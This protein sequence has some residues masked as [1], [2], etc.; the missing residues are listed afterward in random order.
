M[1]RLKDPSVAGN[2]PVEDIR[3]RVLVIGGGA[4]AGKTTAA[5]DVAARYG[6]SVSEGLGTGLVCRALHAE[7]TS[8]SSLTRLCGDGDVRAVVPR[9]L[10]WTPPTASGSP[11]SIEALD[12]RRRVWNRGRLPW[13]K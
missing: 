5:R 8:W 3:W 1:G 2:D 11:L 7:V 6:V 13:L 4:A 10:R 9:S 12:T